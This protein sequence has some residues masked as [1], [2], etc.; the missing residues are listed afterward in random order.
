MQKNNQLAKDLVQKPK[1][2]SGALAIDNN[3]CSLCRP[4]KLPICKGHGGRSG[5]GGGGGGSYSGSDNTD[6]N[7]SE[8]KTPALLYNI[9]VNPPESIQATN[10]KG[11][12]VKISSE[13][14]KA[15][16]K[17]IKALDELLIHHDDK[18]NT[19][20]IQIKPGAKNREELEQL[21]KVIRDECHAFLREKRYTIRDDTA[22]LKDNMLS[23]H[24]HDKELLSE[25]ISHLAKNS[26]S[27]LERAK[28]E[29][30]ENQNVVNDSPDKERKKLPPSPFSSI[31]EGPKPKE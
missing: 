11:E 12:I 29:L 28:K 26:P 20:T 5:G 3:P 15:L 13:Q 31:Q 21:L 30:N 9:K 14:E 27:L 17:L 8:I 18:R 7:K 25:F 19:L 1:K 4:F 10:Q 22:V 24:I 23:I 16:L 2:D 6:S